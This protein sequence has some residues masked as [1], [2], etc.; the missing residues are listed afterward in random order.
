MSM[1]GLI[2][3]LALFVLSGCVTSKAI[4]STRTPISMQH[5]KILSIKTAKRYGYT[6]N[7][8]LS[9]E[10]VPVVNLMAHQGGADA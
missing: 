8:F 6:D 5:K 1:R 9:Q 4:Q 7:S 3:L 10:G 2:I